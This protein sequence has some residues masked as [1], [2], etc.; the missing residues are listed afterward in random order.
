MDPCK[1]HSSSQLPVLTPHVYDDFIFF[2]NR[3]LRE[4]SPVTIVATEFPNFKGQELQA[5]KDMWSVH[6][7]SS[8]KFELGPLPV[9]LILTDR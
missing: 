5:F 9:P 1:N 7:L 4:A 8:P 3:A 2:L 6:P